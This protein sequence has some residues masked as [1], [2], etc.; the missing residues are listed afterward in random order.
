M[1]CFLH[2]LYMAQ[3]MNCDT[4]HCEGCT[5]EQF[6]WK[7]KLVQCQ[8]CEKRKM[9][10]LKKCTKCKLQLCEIVMEKFPLCTMCH[11]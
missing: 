10:Q 6:T 5:P 11:P 4:Y 2:K 7:H 3:C 9:D 1:R 8:T